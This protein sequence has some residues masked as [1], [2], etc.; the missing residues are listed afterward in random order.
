MCDTNVFAVID[1]NILG[2]AI[3][4]DLFQFIVLEKWMQ[5]AVGGVGVPGGREIVG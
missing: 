4:H 5:L 3:V 2:G 1:D